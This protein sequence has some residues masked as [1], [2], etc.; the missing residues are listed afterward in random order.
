MGLACGAHGK[1]VVARKPAFIRLG[2]ASLSMQRSPERREAI[3]TAY[4]SGAMT[5]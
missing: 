3:A 1:L 2:G 4:S 5:L